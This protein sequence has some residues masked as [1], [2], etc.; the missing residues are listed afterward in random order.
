MV[1]ARLAAFAYDPSPLRRV[2]LRSTLAAGTPAIA[3]EVLASAA[4]ICSSTFNAQQEKEEVEK[5][6]KGALPR[7][8][9]GTVATNAAISAAAGAHYYHLSFM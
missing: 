1:R 4:L 7:L 3:A 8:A 9:D 6:W 5:V 2:A